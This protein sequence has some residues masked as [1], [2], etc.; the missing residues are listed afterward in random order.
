[1]LYSRERNPHSPSFGPSGIAGRPWFSKT[2]SGRIIEKAV[3]FDLAY[4]EDSEYY[5]KLQKA[6]RDGNYRPVQLLNQLFTLLEN[7][8]SIGSFFT[9]LLMFKGYF[10]FLILL[11][12]VPRTWVQFRSANRKYSMINNRTP[13]QRKVNYFSYLL[14]NNIFA[15]EIKL[16]SLGSFFLDKYRTALDK[17]YSENR[18]LAEKRTRANALT[19]ILAA[20]SS[21]GAYGIIIYDTIL[22]SITIG[23]MTMYYQAFSRSQSSLDT[24][25]KTIAG[26]YENMLYI[27]NYMEFMEVQGKI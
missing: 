12:V 6:Q 21:Y 23:S 7:I 22:G 9:L 13:E 3:S 8:V 24:F 19:G 10:L 17:F 2:S 26:L 16:F 15:K 11:A 25:L 1:M 18:S 20:L 14:S 4:F 27:R 5:D